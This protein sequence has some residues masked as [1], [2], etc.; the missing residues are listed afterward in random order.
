[1][2]SLDL[3]VVLGAIVAIL[4]AT[5]TFFAVRHQK[6]IAE[7]KELAQVVEEYECIVSC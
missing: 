2:E 7:L 5:S 6:V 1:M 3:T 4:G